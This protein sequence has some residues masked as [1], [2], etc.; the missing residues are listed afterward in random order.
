MSDNSFNL[1]R[2]FFKRE[3]IYSTFSIIIAAVRPL[4]KSN[5]IDKS[6]I[7]LILEN[8][9]KLHLKVDLIAG[10]YSIVGNKKKSMNP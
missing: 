10:V 8:K 7:E 3:Q 6:Y 4:D 2:W 1:I 9:E 5:E